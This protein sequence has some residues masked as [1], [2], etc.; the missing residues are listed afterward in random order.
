MECAKNSSGKREKP[1][2]GTMASRVGIPNEKVGC[3]VG[4]EGRH[5]ELVVRLEEDTLVELVGPLSKRGGGA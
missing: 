1:M 5:G 2:P 4:V 3:Q